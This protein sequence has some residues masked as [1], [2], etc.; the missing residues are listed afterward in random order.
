MTRSVQRAIRGP[1]LLPLAAL[2]LVATLHTLGHPSESHAMED[3]PAA[4][5]V[6]SAGSSEPGRARWRAP[7]SGNRDERD[8][9]RGLPTARQWGHPAP[10][11]GM[12][13]MSVCLAVLTGLV[14][15][16]LGGGTT[17]ARDTATTPVRGRS[18]ATPSNSESGVMTVLGCQR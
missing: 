10:A 17:G 15:L 2:P 12:V 11:A 16:L 3:V 1:R 13:P 7:H 18:I 8:D 6:A 4:R 5:S 14:L 9:R